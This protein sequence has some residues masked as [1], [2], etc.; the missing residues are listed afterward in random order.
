MIFPVSTET[1]FRDAMKREQGF[2]V[3]GHGPRQ[4]ASRVADAIVRAVTRPKPE[5]YPY[6][7]ARLL[8][9]LNAFAPALSDRLI[10]RFGRR[11]VT[12]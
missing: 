3:S 10:R 5:V 9:I 8:S 6:A 12:R 4:P 2:E 1:E 7:P 11:P